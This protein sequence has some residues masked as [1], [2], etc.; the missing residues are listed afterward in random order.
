MSTKWAL[1]DTRELR[2]GALDLLRCAFGRT[3]DF[4]EGQWEAIEPLLSGAK[5]LLVVQRTG[6]GK[7]VV[8]FLATKLLRDAGSGPTLLISPLLA[9][10]RNQVDMAAKLGL[11]AA[12]INSANRDQ[13]ES[14]ERQIL[15]GEL[16]LLLVSPE[17]LA[18]P[19]FREIL[20]PVFQHTSGLIVIDEAHCIS[21]WGHDFRPDYRRIL[22]VLA[23]ASP[24]ASV[25]ATTATANNRVIADLEEQL[26]PG[27]D[28]Q[29]GTLV[30]DSLRLSVFRMDEPAER[31]AWLAKFLPRM[32]GTGIVYA[33]T[34]SEAERVA[35]WLRSVGI[36]ACAYH[37]DLDDMRRRELEQAFLGNRLKALVATTA[38]GMGYDKLDVGFV[39]HCGMPGSPLAY[40]QQVGRAGRAVNT[41][42]GAL[43]WCEDDAEVSEHFIESALPPRWIFEALLLGLRSG[44]KTVTECI[45]GLRATPP[46]VVSHALEVLEAE[47]I[48]SRGADGFQIADNGSALEWDRIEAIRAERRHELDQMQ[49]YAAHQSC[50]MQLL[51]AML[52]EPDPQPCGRCDVCQPHAQAHVPEDLV[53]TAREFLQGQVF[54]IR[55]IPRLPRRTDVGRKYV[56][57]DNERLLPGIALSSYNDPGWGR[58]VREGKYEAL[59]FSDAL[60]AASAGAISKCGIAFDWLTWVPSTNHGKAVERFA[61]RLAEALGI[62]AVEAVRRKEHRAPQK[63]MGT[64]ES[65]FLNAWGAFEVLT[66]RK[67]NCLLVDDVVDSGWTLAVIGLE[68]RNKGS[69]PVMPFALAT[70]RPR[71]YA[72]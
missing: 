69:G 29:R 39:V 67:G 41:A 40:Y 52:D 14:I 22:G 49:L 64:K 55:P 36:E 19:A 47:G 12:S 26:G 38:L 21:D 50:R 43:L 45:S 30:R 59:E 71:R 15:M 54:E 27:L 7:S 33:L 17:R 2:S 66:A 28:V 35:K 46:P 37:A 58:M 51:L 6:W 10:M 13:R 56:L 24:G 5:R 61:R 70:A 8:Y 32:P 62:E 23:G 25:L 11:K 20:L 63:A 48:L 34:V 9:L 53:D 42:H 1:R 31:L 4:R 16:D 57:K 60:L 72:E 44:P 68:L 3:A 65:Q 18:D